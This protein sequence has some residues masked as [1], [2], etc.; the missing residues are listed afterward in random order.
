MSINTERYYNTHQKQ[1]R[2]YGNWAFSDRAET[3]INFFTGTYSEAVRAA[4][5]WAKQ[6]NIIVLYVLG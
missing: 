5:K 2:G 1:P 6:N 4:K 3:R